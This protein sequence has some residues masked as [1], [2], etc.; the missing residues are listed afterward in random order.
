MKPMLSFI[1]NQ[2][3]KP[4]GFFG[5]IISGV[6][7]MGNKSIYESVI[8][9]LEIRQHEKILEI[10]YG[11]GLGIDRIASAY[12]CLVTGI[13]FSELMF[14]EAQKRN[15][16]HIAGNKVAL[17]YGDFLNHEFGFNNFDKAFC[18]NVIY[19]WEPL[20]KP[21]LKLK[22][23]LR[24]GGEFYIYMVNSDNLNKMKF[25]KSGIFNKYTIGQV[26]DEL[27]SAGFVNIKYNE[28]N[29][30]YLIKCKK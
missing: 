30:G 23:E 22:S 8:P 7:K 29:N 21:F 5:K 4:T 12:D 28:Q 18:I 3:R 11:H 2:F 25:T 19:F 15:K 16:R 26:V 13:D 20:E 1:G 27:Q 9:E 24:S 14:K 6:M 17:Y 10:G